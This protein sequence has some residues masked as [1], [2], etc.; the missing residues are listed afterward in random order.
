MAPNPKG[1]DYDPRAAGKHGPERILRQGVVQ[2]LEDI[3][4]QDA[5]EQNQSPQ[6]H[7]SSRI[8]SCREA[9]QPRK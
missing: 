2:Q 3:N 4:S 8:D 6:E 5:D 1:K 9:V 7:F